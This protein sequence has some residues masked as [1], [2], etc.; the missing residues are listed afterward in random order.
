M[1]GKNNP[2]IMNSWAMY[3]WANSVY[4]LVITSTIFPIFYAAKTAGNKQLVNG[5]EVDFVVFF[6]RQFINNE[7]YSYV[8]SASFFVVVLLAPLLSGIADYTDGKKTFLKIFMTLGSISCMSLYFFDVNRLELSMASIFFA[9]LG[10][11]GSLVYYN[12]YLPQIAT[13]EIQDKISAKG[14][15]LGYIGSVLLLVIIL[16]LMKGFA[17][18]KV[19]ETFVI[20]G[21]WWIVFGWFF[22][23]RLPKGA[24]KKKKGSLFTNG[25]KELQN[26]FLEFTKQKQTLRYLLAFFVFNT[27]IQTVML[28][29]AMFGEKEINWPIDA[30]GN[31]DTTGLIISIIVIQI[32]AI[33]GATA[34]S[35]LSKKYGNVRV[36]QFSLLLWVL[37]ASFAY[38]ITEPKEFYV[39]AALVGFVMGGTQSLSRSTYSKLLPETNDYASYFSFYEVLEKIGL[40]IGPTLFGLA[41]AI[42]G[43]M[44][45]SVLVMI[46]FFIV[47]LVL[48][49]LVKNF[50][51]KK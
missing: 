48:L 18:I 35:R 50:G 4:S 29:A 44:R 10:F 34:M 36:L 40:I 14:F 41:I 19:E 13:T 12:A 6:G 27:G 15:S 11:W 25:Y 31:K 2:K 1:Q 32:I 23:Q 46:S 26:T 8:F 37:A 3:D 47:G 45:T 7:L 33:G 16:V 22:V 5:N 24:P 30:Q 17:I 28:L 43:T 21:I 42:T 51:E 9:S 20:V 39:L 49:F 38:F